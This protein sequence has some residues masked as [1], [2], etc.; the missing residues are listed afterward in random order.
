MMKYVQKTAEV[1][2]AARIKRIITHCDTVSIIDRFII[3]KGTL[4]NTNLHFIQT[5]D[6]IPD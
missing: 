2:N 6:S 4:H 3:P 1:R 5:I